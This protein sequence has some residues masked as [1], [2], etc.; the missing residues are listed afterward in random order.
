MIRHE[1]D[2]RWSVVHQSAD[3][4]QSPI[5]T[6]G[7]AGTTVRASA[8][9]AADAAR[10]SKLALAAI[11]IVTVVVYAGSFT[12]TWISDDVD[13]IV[14]QPAVQSL[15]PSSVYA[16]ATTRTDS[17]NFIPL[18]F[19]SLA[20]DWRLWGARPWGFHLTNLALHIATA[21]AIYFLVLRLHDAPGLAAATTLLWAMHPVQVES[22]AWISERKNLLSTL[23]F[24]LAFLAYLRLELRPGAVRYAAVLTWYCAA[25]LSK[26]NTIVLPALLLW[27]EI[28]W[29]RRI[30]AADLVRMVPLLACGG[31]IA[32]LNLR[33]NPS[34][35]VAY[36][37][38]SFAVTMR[39]TATVIP[40]YLTNVVAPFDLMSYYPVPL[41]DSWLDPTVA[42]SV[43]LIAALVALVL[44][45]TARGVPEGFWLAWFG[46]TLA[47][48]LNLV[49]FPALMNDRYLYLPLV[50]ALVFLLRQGCRLVSPRFMPVVVGVIALTF[51]GLTAM[52]IPAY[53]DPLS[54]WADMGLRTSY[55]TADQPFGAGP[56]T[57]EKRLLAEA[58][59]R[60]PTRAWLH[61]NIGGVA[62]EDNRLGD[63]LQSLERAYE[64]DPTDPVIALNLGRTYLRLARIDDAIRTLEVAT[65]LE[66][67]SFFAHLNL[68]R[69][70]LLKGNLVAARAELTR[71]KAIKADA[72]FWQAVEQ[73]LAR[74]E[75]RGS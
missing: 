62:F 60:H 16:L 1:R 71:A 20:I 35:G 30:R 37:G 11:A 24:L 54:L 17:V 36:H 10:A 61:N 2:H 19:L 42:S 72:Y 29:H 22:V 13:M 50:G 26:V 31:A 44:W 4:A 70:Q 63:A 45:L 52:R 56:R 12:G 74:A 18:S 23:F 47:P 57:E 66:P 6:C 7:L 59:A 64:L 53:H 25:L 3:G 41:R 75:Q 15:T 14:E 28:V 49:P 51:A 73:A 40:R 65:A 9:P 43:V 32:W 55:I 27:Y 58:V 46:I 67:P 33:G 5:V 48:M 69:A 39:T 68:A 38:G 21:C 8:V 34:H